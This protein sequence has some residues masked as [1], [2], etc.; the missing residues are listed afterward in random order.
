MYINAERFPPFFKNEMSLQAWGGGTHL[1]SLA[2][3]KL[4]Q[5][6]CMSPGVREP[7][8][9]HKKILPQKTK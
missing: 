1:Q 2:L 9:P 5:V 3:C 6:E 7:L 8:G 4:K